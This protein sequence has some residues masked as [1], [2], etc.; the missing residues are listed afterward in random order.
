MMLSVIN[1]M[2]STNWLL[3]LCDNDLHDSSDLDYPHSLKF[4]ILLQFMTKFVVMTKYGGNF[5]WCLSQ[6]Q[7]WFELKGPVSCVHMK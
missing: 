7:T 6:V 2:I 5:C 4:C 1:L 3:N